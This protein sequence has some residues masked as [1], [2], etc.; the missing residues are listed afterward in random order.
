ML[1]IKIKPKNGSGARAALRLATNDTHQRM[2]G[3]KPFAQIAAGTLPIGQYRDLLQSLFVFHSA[4]G[5]VARNGGWL[6]LSSSET[7]LDL[8][9]SD[10]AFL[11]RAVPTSIVDWQAG[12]GEAALGALY[13][14]EGS[15]LGGR[16]IAR[17][18]DYLFGSQ[19]EGRRFF[20]GC[21][22]DRA[23]WACLIGVVEEACGHGRPLDLAISGALR[24]FEWFE[25]CISPS[26]NARPNPDDSIVA[27]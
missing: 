3:L 1:G 7:R 13:A 21:P 2:H 6:S 19:V 17:Q 9:R 26:S 16:V 22:D 20:V 8:L 15:M 11:D 14:A 4:V 25:Q 24:T 18:L 5:Q 10:L 12:P 23:K 27:G